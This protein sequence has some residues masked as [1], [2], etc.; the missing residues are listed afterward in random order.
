MFERGG[1]VFSPD[2]LEIFLKKKSFAFHFFFSFKPGRFSVKQRFSSVW[3]QSS[4]NDFLQILWKKKVFYFSILFMIFSFALV[5]QES[6]PKALN[7]KTFFTVTYYFVLFVILSQLT[8]KKIFI[9]LN[10]LFQ[11]FLSRSLIR[12]FSPEMPRAPSKFSFSHKITNNKLQSV[13]L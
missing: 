2:L 8:K 12:T 7:R 3:F 13:R 9:D 4:K 11:L 6:I 10:Y 1:E 5:F